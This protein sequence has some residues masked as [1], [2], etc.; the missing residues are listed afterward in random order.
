M[1]GNGSIGMLFFAYDTVLMGEKKR[2]STG[3]G[4][5]VLHFFL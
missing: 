5:G 2:R 3:N 4:E 1:E